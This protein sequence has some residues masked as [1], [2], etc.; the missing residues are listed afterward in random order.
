[1]VRA[2]NVKTRS[3]TRSISFWRAI[4]T[5]RRK[6]CRA[7]GAVHRQLYV[8]KTLLSGIFCQSATMVTYCAKEVKY[9]TLKHR[10]IERWGE[11]PLRNFWVKATHSEKA[12]ICSYMC[13]LSFRTLTPQINL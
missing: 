7:H 3:S 4:R 6:P 10:V 11:L 8:Q 1:M 9:C 13:R 2:V 12:R 5:R